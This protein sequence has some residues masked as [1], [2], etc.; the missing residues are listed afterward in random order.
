MCGI[1]G[2]ITKTGTQGAPLQ[3]MMD[4]IHYRG[5]DDSGYAL[6]GKDTEAPLHDP[7]SDE[8]SMVALAHRRLSIV[9]LSSLGHQPMSY[10]DG[11]YW[12]TYNGE[13]YNYI[14]I[15]EE[16]KALGHQFV[17]QSDS[18]VIL[19]AYAQ[20]G[21]DCL[22]R[23]NGMWAFAIYD[24]EKKTVFLTRDRFGI[25]PLYYWT[26]PDGVYYFASEI[27]QFTI[28]SGWSAVVNPQRAY[29]F[30]AWSLMDHTNE[31]M[32]QGV[33]QLLPGHYMQ[34]SVNDHFTTGAV[35]DSVK[36][37]NLPL[38]KFEGTFE[39]ATKKFHSL[40]QDSVRLMLRADVPVGSCLSGGLDS[41]S[42]V[43]LMDDI[44]D[45][46][47]EQ[48]TFSATAEVEKYNERRWI[49]EVVRHTNVDAHYVHPSLDD[50]FADSEKI[51]WHQDEPFGSTSIYAQW[52]VFQLASQNN[53]TVMLDGQGADEQLAGYHSFFAP[54]FYKL[55][56]S[57]RWIS[58]IREIRAVKCLHGYSEWKAVQ[59]IANMMIPEAIKS[60]L[61]K[62]MGKNHKAPPWLNV[63]LLGARAIDPHYKLGSYT[64]NIQSVC[65]A[66]LTGS[67]LQALLHWEDRDSMAHSLESRV[68]F[69]D[70][71]LVEFSLSLPDHFKISGGKTKLILR[72][73]M[74]G[75]LP[76]K[77]RDRVDKL[78][79]ATP[80]EVW[81][82]QKET[83]T[84][85]LKL[86]ESVNGLQGIVTPDIMT[87]FSDMVTGKTP[88]SF[89][90]W[91]IINFA[92]WA[93][94][95]NVRLV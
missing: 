16:L 19:A 26:S 61:K 45:G 17:S 10:Q 50:L 93:R 55:F 89:T 85:R 40:L 39:E 54:L 33:Y 23:F 59:H 67:N 77:I 72:G 52:K 65:H 90:V 73:A 91:R 76:D 69:L 38:K 42:I 11:R 36:W 44:L 48:K 57:G 53:V 64:D 46:N 60:P 2:Y 15:R 34:L 12:L 75:V 83:E 8:E 70:Y 35:V 29:D 6:F 63:D 58:L 9:D 14:E 94:I 66:Q 28:L 88:F 32:F 21:A 95:F 13:I 27:K 79:F 49:D 56:K 5:P 18:E 51:T 82:R 92:Q 31:T 68:P 4:I 62:I 41:S 24:R 87:Y 20:W 81:I 43:C 30:L 86:K 1:G 74:D 37:Y 47:G 25:K 7:L 3:D 22:S 71:R 84:F 78:G 80:E